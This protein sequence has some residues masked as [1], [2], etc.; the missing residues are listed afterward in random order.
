MN[1]EVFNP[2]RFLDASGALDKDLSSN[3]LIFSMGKRR[4]IGEELSKM[5]LFLYTSLLAHQCLFSADPE[6]PPKMDFEYGLSLK[7]KSFKITVTHRDTMDLLDSFVEKLLDGVKK[8]DTA[9]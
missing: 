6:R 3:V 4:C 1:P 9:G 2:L 7:P 5:K 8:E